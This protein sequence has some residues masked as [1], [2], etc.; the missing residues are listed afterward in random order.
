MNN[1][2]DCIIIDIPKVDSDKGSL[3]FLE[4]SNQIPFEAMIRYF[5]NDPYYQL[6][7]YFQVIVFY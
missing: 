6:V 1:V 5:K 7:F 4:S 3:S 2:E